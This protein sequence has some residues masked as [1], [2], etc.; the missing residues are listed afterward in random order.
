MWLCSNKI[1]YKNRWW[2]GF[3]PWP[4]V[5]QLLLYTLPRK[6]SFTMCFQWPCASKDVYLPRYTSV[7][8]WGP[9]I[10]KPVSSI[11]YLIPAFR[12]VKG[13]SSLTTGIMFFSLKSGVPPVFFL[14]KRHCHLYSCTKQKGGVSFDTCPSLIF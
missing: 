7:T 3:G 12:C 1:I 4:G 13:I 11:A 8:P 14:S 2:A 9:S 6:V 5:C 10:H